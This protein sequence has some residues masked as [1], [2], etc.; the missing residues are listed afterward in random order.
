MLVTY[1]YNKCLKSDD[2]V[3]KIQFKWCSKMSIWGVTLVFFVEKNEQE[4][5]SVFIVE[6][7]W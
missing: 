3:S 4:N 5:I 1:D 6:F 7:L 2:M